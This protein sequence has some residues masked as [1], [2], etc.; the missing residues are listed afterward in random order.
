MAHATDDDRRER[1]PRHEG[2]HD[3]GREGERD[4]GDQPDER[5]SEPDAASDEPGRDSVAP[6]AKAT[7]PRTASYVFL[8]VVTLVTL[9]SDLASKSWVVS[10]LDN[11]A[12]G[13]PSRVEVWR[14]RIQFISAKNRGGAWGLL[15]G[16]ADWIRKPFFFA[17]SFAAVLFI[18]SLYRKLEPRQTALKWGLPLVLGGALGNL[19]DRI[20]Y[21][22]VVD[23][24]D[25]R[26]T[27][28]YHW[29]TFNIADI[30]ICVGVGLMA[31]DMFTARPK[32]AAAEVG[33]AA[34]LRKP[35]SAA[36]S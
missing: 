28:T 8:A 5:A 3:D 26:L 14:E 17:V 19:A 33:P 22:H 32:P 27:A 25:V 12:P 16:E 1:S 29:P 18:L 10:R 9:V 20:R 2:G 13:Q 7:P 23:F 34:A 15:G 6:M 31:I 11:P 35:K 21:G 4:D 24:I 30:G 36:R